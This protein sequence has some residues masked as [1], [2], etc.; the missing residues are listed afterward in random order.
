LKKDDLAFGPDLTVLGSDTFESYRLGMFVSGIQL[1]GFKLN[2]EAGYN[3][4]SEE[5]GGDSSPYLQ[6]GISRSF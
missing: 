4:G 3:F 1:G 6:L 5:G 2:T